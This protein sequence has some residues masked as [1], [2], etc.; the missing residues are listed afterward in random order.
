MCVHINICVCTNTCVYIHIYIPL[1]KIHNCLLLPGLSLGLPATHSLGIGR[2]NLRRLGLAQEH[3][4]SKTAC[5]VVLHRG[6][7]TTV[8]V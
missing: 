4:T 2:A 8:L 7:W 5:S 6:D 1:N 3:V